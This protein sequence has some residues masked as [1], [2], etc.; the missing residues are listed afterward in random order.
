MYFELVRDDDQEV[1]HR[2][3]YPTMNRRLVI[4]KATGEG[5]PDDDRDDKA[6]RAV[7]VKI[8]RFHRSE[9]CWPRRGTYAA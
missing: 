8:T 7:F 2:F 5:R 9:A 4:E 1:E 6:C 3:G